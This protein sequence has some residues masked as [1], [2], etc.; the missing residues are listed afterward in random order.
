MATG[1]VDGVQ[2]PATITSGGSRSSGS[3]PVRPAAVGQ[4]KQAALADGNATLIVVLAEE[5]AAEVAA[6][7][8]F[9]IG[10]GEAV[11]AQRTQ[12][13]PGAT[14]APLSGPVKAAACQPG[15]AARTA[16]A[17]CDRRRG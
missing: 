10:Q 6:A 2:I 8:V 9:L 11:A 17:S 5:Q 15:S 4:Q 13:I 14:Q 7:Q 1:T 3:A 16:A 12:A